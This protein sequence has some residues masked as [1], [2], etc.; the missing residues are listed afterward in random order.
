MENVGDAKIELLAD[1]GNTPHH[2]RELA[3]RHDAVLDVIVRRQRSHSAES[4]LSAFPKELPLGFV[5]GY[6]DLASAVAL[7][8]RAG[9]TKRAGCVFADAL[10]FDNQYRFGV[11][12]K[13]NRRAGFHRLDGCPVHHLESR[14][15]DT[16]RRD[17]DDSL[18]RRI[19]LVE[20]CQ[21]RAYGLA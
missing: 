1:S 12:G 16:C 17:I 20:D 4:A 19:H 6:P 9:K 14:G 21:Q 11:A 5:F 8:D 13:T 2:L 7:A 3:A 15:N 10:D 18:S